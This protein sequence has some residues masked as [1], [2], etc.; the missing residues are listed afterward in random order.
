MKKTMVEDVVVEP[1]TEEFILW[2]CLH[3]GPL[4]RHTID[5][6]SS[7]DKMPWDRYRKR[8]IPLLIKITRTYGAC[9]II[10]RDG[11]EI[12]GQLRFYP[13]AICNMDGA[14]CMCLQQNHPAGP[15]DN[16]ADSD[17]P[18]LAQIED[19]TLV[20]HCMM[21]GSPQQKKNPYQRK[22][23]STHMVRALI[24]WAK[25][26]GWERIEVDSFEN[27]P[28]IYETTG[29]AGHIFWEK[30]GFHLADRHPHPE[31]QDRSQFSEFIKSLEEQAKSIG[32]PPERAID[33]LV[34]RLELT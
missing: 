18:T 28:I 32:I 9:A 13:K 5:K 1:M 6:W 33:Q 4:A 3:G 10:A 22:G 7:A 24:E 15:A 25:S 2:R 34:M 19:K 8:N 12:V 11:S 31:L 20:V 23:I 21:T 14:G 29:S 30:I 17:F 27:I 26:K 16:F